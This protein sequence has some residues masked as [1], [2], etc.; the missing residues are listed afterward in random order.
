M[1]I[2]KFFLIIFTFCCIWNPTDY[3]AKT[4]KP[5]KI[6]FIG[7]SYTYRNHMPKMLMKIAQAHGKKIEVHWNVKGKTSIY[8]HSLRPQLFKAITWKKWDYVV[9]QGSSRDMLKTDSIFYGKT[10]PALNKIVHT[11]RQNHSKTN[12]LFFMTWAYRKGYKKMSKANTH[13]KMIRVIS[14][15]Y[16]ELAK[17]YNAR[18]IPIGLIWEKLIFKHHIKNLYHKDNGHPSSVGSYVT[19]CSFYSMIF[20]RRVKHTPQSY[21][22]IKQHNKIEELVWNYSKREM[23]HSFR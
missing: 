19:A 15:K 14:S 7:N 13:F 11:I 23:F 21:L 9:L 8:R 3:S 6:L 16:A 10:I 5:I 22:K 20:D 18:V 2:K 1:K 4:I 12:I 17:K